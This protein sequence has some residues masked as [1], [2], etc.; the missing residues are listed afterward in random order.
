MSDRRLRVLEQRPR[1]EPEDCA[2][3]LRAQLR[4]GLLREEQLRVAAQAGDLSARLALSAPPP[5]ARI[6]RWLRE[7]EA[8][9]PDSL[10]Q[11]VLATVCVGLEQVA[12][13]TGERAELREEV[14]VRLAQVRRIA[15]GDKTRPDLNATALPLRWDPFDRLTRRAYWTLWACAWRQQPSERVRSLLRLAGRWLRLPWHELRPELVDELSAWALHRPTRV[16][17]WFG[18]TE[19]ADGRSEGA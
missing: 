17:D 3:L 8:L 19:S 18:P 4:A 10:V 15:C 11:V 14:R 5:P 7:L 13:R 1:I 12:L 16:E 9:R 6:F 2:R